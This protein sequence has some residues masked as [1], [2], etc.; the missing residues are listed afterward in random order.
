M[1]LEAILKKQV[2]AGAYSVRPHAVQHAL[3]EGFAPKHIAEA[4]LNGRIIEIYPGRNRCLVYGR[5]R[6]TARVNLELHA[7][8]DYG[9]PE[10]LDIV[11]AY[12][13]DNKV[14]ETPPTKRRRGCRK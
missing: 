10:M 1:D 14:W 6:L 8:C 7:V 2:Q 11:T 5:A 9:D 12:I 4:I 3:A 13:P